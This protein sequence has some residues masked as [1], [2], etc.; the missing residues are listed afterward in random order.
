MADKSTTDLLGAACP[1][2][3]VCNRELT[4]TGLGSS[5]EKLL[6]GDAVGKP[7][8]SV[9]TILK[10]EI[11]QPVVDFEAIRSASRHLFMVR[12][13]DYD[14]MLRG[15][16]HATQSELMFLVSLR[17]KTPQQLAGLGLSIGDYANHDSAIE[18]LFMQQ[19]QSTQLVDL[20]AMVTQLK[21]SLDEKR[22]HEEAENSL[23][24]ELK[25]AADI[26]VRFDR[27]GR[28]IDFRWPQENYHGEKLTAMVGKSLEETLPSLAK[29]VD[30]SMAQAENQ[31]APVAIEFDVTTDQSR[32][33]F[34][35][36]LAKT[37]RSNFMLMGRDITERYELQQ[38]LEHRT[39]HDSVT[40]LGNRAWFQQSVEQAQ[41]TGNPIAILVADLNDFKTI[42]DRLGH[43]VGDATL[44]EIARRLK[45]WG[46]AGSSV[47]RLGGDEFGVL[48]TSVQTIEQ[49]YQNALLLVDVI[50]QPLEVELCR[51]DPKVSVGV[52]FDDEGNPLANMLRDADFA[53][54]DAKGQEDT[55]VSVCDNKLREKLLDRMTIRCDL[56]HAITN[57]EFVPFYQPLV[58][59][60]TNQIVGFEALA[61]WIHPKK[62]ILSPYF[63]LD[64]AE[65]NGLITDI[66]ESILRTACQDIYE[67]NALF[68][69]QNYRV[70]V[71][72]A[73][74]QLQDVRLVEVV[75]SVLAETG[76]A[77][78]CLT[79][80]IT[81]TVLIEDLTQ[82]KLALQTLRQGGVR[83][84][85]DDFGSGYSSL[86]YIH[87]F[88]IDCLKLDRSLISNINSSSNLSCIVE[89]VVDL[90]KKL[91]LSIVAEGIETTDQSNAIRELG[92][93]Y[94]QGYLFAK[95]IPL[96]E[97]IILLASP[98]PIAQALWDN[99]SRS[100]ANANNAN[101]EKEVAHRSN[102][103]VN[104]T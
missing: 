19:A 30:A 72:L 66:G 62:G 20:N 6:G 51:V 12:L 101:A 34:D 52:A 32:Y 97:L 99:D 10:P 43:H 71:N 27:A 79:V 54:Y 25:A 40:N 45:A 65:E 87:Q 61:R 74:R 73:P 76:L 83:V 46:P 33:H 48:L 70:N 3:I 93:D 50:T 67:L 55:N 81:E 85:L 7:L 22:R 89:C 104:L 102:S 26:S 29:A 94:G 57:V 23:T 41:A 96:A 82:A 21:D 98:D 47:A 5:L 39:L 36:R 35:A 58:D 42:N 53:M 84:A 49:A 56:P 68:P 11:H 28:I 44:I 31:E 103:G 95:P 88:P 60:K 63:F 15:Q 90:G 92:C 8:D 1:F 59:F 17:C 9:A 18:T 78:Q 91:G 38:R 75:E 100:N 64:V 2:N 16:V 77:P 80:E 13:D 4:I 86:N 69:D 24:H 37:L 14:I